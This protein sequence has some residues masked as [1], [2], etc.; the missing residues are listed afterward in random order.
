[1]M[2]LSTEIIA[3]S[4]TTEKGCSVISGCLLDCITMIYLPRSVF[5]FCSKEKFFLGFI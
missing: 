1:M 5:V 4:V 3:S 2:K